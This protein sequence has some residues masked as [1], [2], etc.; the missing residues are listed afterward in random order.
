MKHIIQVDVYYFRSSTIIAFICIYTWTERQRRREPMKKREMK[1]Y[2]SFYLTLIEQTDLIRVKW[3]YYQLHRPLYIDFDKV[4]FILLTKYCVRNWW[5]NSIFWWTFMYNIDI[6]GNV[7]YDHWRKLMISSSLFETK[8]KKRETN[9]NV[10]LL[11]MT[12][13]Y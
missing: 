4:F 9:V 8:S 2:I 12:L 5:Y 1:G 7:Y 6:I 11:D 13:S 3:E 10:L